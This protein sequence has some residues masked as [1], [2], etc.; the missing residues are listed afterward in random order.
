SIFDSR[1]EESS[2]VQYFQ[3]YGYLAQQQ[4]MMQDYIRTSTYQRAILQNSIDFQNKVVLD[5]GA[6]SGILSF[7]AVQAGARK[8]YAVEAS[9]IAIHAENLIHSNQLSPKIQIVK[10]RIEEIEIPEPID[11]IIS[12]PMGY[13]LFN[14]RMLETFLHA[15]K[16]LKSDGL[17]F[18]TIANLYFA[19]F[20][21]ES[22]YIEQ[23]CKANFWHQ[24]AF[25][26]IDLTSLQQTALSE[27]FRQPI[28]DTFDVRLLLSRPSCYTTDFRTTDETDLHNIHIPYSISIVTTGIMHGLAFWFDV[29]FA[30][31]ATSIWLSTAPHEP[32]THWYQVRCL[33]R[34]PLFVRAGDVIT[35]HISMVANTRQSYDVE[36]MTVLQSTGVKTVAEVDL[37]NPYFRY[38]LGQPYVPPGSNKTSPTES[39]W[40]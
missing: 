4:N 8:V 20:S 37:K 16:W 27:I 22:L 21:D 14:E 9:S 6:G 28:V 11:M 24:R 2:A 5:V 26:G 23:S 7:F 39:Y 34:S 32:L 33:F 15:K 18:P 3:F 40:S 19:P 13:M 38:S 10:G 30:G 25:Y 17:I 1:T 29:E 12:E 31:S 35:G 36:I